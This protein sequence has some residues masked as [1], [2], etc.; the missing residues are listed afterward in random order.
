M[1]EESMISTTKHD[2]IIQFLL[3]NWIIAIL[4]VFAGIV[5]AIPQLRDG[6]KLIIEC[7]KKLFCKKKIEIASSQYAPCSY[8]TIAEGDRLRHIDEAKFRQ[9]GILIVI[10]KKG[11]YA[12]C[13]VGDPYNMNIQTFKINELTKAN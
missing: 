8:W 9:Y 10:N 4:V 6:A 12:F 1:E 11:E 7:S 5:M 3:D 2:I 13:I